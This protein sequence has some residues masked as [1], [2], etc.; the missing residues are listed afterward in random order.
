MTV[1][2]GA[3]GDHQIYRSGVG[4]LGQGEA[5][6]RYLFVLGEHWV[7]LDSAGV[8]EPEVGTDGG[9]VLLDGEGVGERVVRSVRPR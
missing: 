1:L 9:Q 2:Q 5:I 3:A 8:D 7:S 4:H 6:T